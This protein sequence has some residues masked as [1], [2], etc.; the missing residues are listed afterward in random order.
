MRPGTLSLGLT[1]AV[2]AAAFAAQRASPVAGYGLAALT[3]VVIVVQATT[4]MRVWP[5]RHGPETPYLFGIFW[6][7]LLGLIAPYLA[8]RVATEGPGSLIDTLLAD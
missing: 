2:G 6:G 3:M 4:D 7:L 5:T 8:L 1:V